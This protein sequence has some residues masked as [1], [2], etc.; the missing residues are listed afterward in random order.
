M[1]EEL[2]NQ[3]PPRFKRG[4]VVRLKSDGASEYPMTVSVES[5]APQVLYFNDGALREVSI[6][7]E[8]LEPCEPRTVV[9]F[10]AGEFRHDDQ[11]DD[12]QEDEDRA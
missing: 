1:S 8:C 4:D 7:Q 12:E 5:V 3:P 11:P 10:S 2:K 6:H 9:G